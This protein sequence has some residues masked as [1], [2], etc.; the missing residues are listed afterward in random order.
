MRNTRLETLSPEVIDMASLRVLSLRGTDFT[1]LNW[2]SYSIKE[3]PDGLFTVKETVDDDGPL[4]FA[5]VET[6]LAS[7]V[8]LEVCCGGGLPK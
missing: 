2:N 4:T 3:F 7:G 1:V 5:D 8:G 6:I